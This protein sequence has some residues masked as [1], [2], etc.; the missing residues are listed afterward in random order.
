MKY[1]D[2]SRVTKVTIR[3]K[4]LFFA[5]SGA[6]FNWENFP[7]LRAPMAWAE[8]GI[9]LD[10]IGLDWIGLD[11][12]GLDWIGLDWIYLSDEKSEELAYFF[13]FVV[14]IEVALFEQRA[15]CER[16]AKVDQDSHSRSID[17]NGFQKIESKNQ[18]AMLHGAIA[19]VD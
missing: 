13:V 12:I 17:G 4:D 16:N 2:P 11:W 6:L 9:G 5:K 18:S 8:Y 14:Q 1:Q 3:L 10:W 7:L 19:C 15:T